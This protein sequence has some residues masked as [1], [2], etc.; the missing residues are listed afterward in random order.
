MTSKL[1]PKLG[2]RYSFEKW[3]RNINTEHSTVHL[4]VGRLET[5]ALKSPRVEPKPEYYI[6]IDEN[7]N[8]DSQ[9]F[10]SAIMLYNQLDMLRDKI[11]KFL[12]LTLSYCVNKNNLALDIVR[13]SP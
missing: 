9:L 7:S 4:C 3:N 5:G 12:Y 6:F 1:F 2:G 10:Q 11:T 13:A 8:F